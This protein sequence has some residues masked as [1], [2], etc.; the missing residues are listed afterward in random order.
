LVIQGT[1]YTVLSAFYTYYNT[2]SFA[3]FSFN[4]GYSITS[5]AIG[6][7]SKTFATQANLPLTAGNAIT[8]T[9]DGGRF[10][11]GTVTSYNNTTGSLVCNITSVAG[12][13]TFAFWS[14]QGQTVPNFQGNVS[15]GD[16]VWI[17]ILNGGMTSNWYQVFDI[18]TSGYSGF[19]SDSLSR[20]GTCIFA[21]FAG[22]TYGNVTSVSVIP[23]ATGYTGTAGVYCV[24]HVPSV[25][26]FNGRPLIRPVGLTTAAL[27]ANI[28]QN[29]VDL[30]TNRSIPF[31]VTTLA[32][33][34]TIPSTVSFSLEAGI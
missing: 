15:L 11:S 25:S 13:G 29:D 4:T 20:S 33:V 22:Y 26:N 19:Y 10:M 31:R 21:F 23:T 12:S 5:V 32:G 27:T 8:I 18:T 28:I 7:G 3:S 2:D 1:G 16:T 30:M 6:T 14:I 24:N 34:A 17:G 9:Y